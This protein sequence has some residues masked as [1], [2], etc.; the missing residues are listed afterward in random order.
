MDGNGIIIMTEYFADIKFFR[1]TMF[2]E[3]TIFQKM[4][5]DVEEQ[6]VLDAFKYH[7]F[8]QA[9]YSFIRLLDIDYSEGFCCN[10]CGN[11][12]STII[13]DGTSLSFRRA[14]DSWQSFIGTVSSGK[15]RSG[16]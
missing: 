6:L 9:W 7:H 1:T 16:R 14:L 12:P 13:M 8:R 5:S 15:G 2:T 3:Y 10:L 11:H 4:H